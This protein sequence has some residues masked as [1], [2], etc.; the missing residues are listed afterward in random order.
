LRAILVPLAHEKGPTSCD[1]D[2][3]IIISLP[4][5]PTYGAKLRRKKICRQR[6]SLPLRDA[7]LRGGGRGQLLHISR[8]KAAPEGA[9]S[10][11]GRKS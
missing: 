6:D 8:K 2:P 4:D 10:Q 7:G 3:F 11:T 1:D 9:A 5:W